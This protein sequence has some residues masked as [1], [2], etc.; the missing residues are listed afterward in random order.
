MRRAGNLP[1]DDDVL[2]RRQRPVLPGAAC[3]GITTAPAQFIFNGEGGTVLAWSQGVDPANATIV[4]DD[5]AGGAVH[6]GLAIASNGV[7]NFLY[8]T[9]FHNGTMRWD[10][11]RRVCFSRQALEP[12][13]RGCTAALIYGEP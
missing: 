9:D 2:R 10:N 12:K 8:A 1:R 4:Y 13:R 3:T 6:K 7:G 5:G 11:P